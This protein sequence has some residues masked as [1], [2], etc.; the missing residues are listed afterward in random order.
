M[1]SPGHRSLGDRLAE[2]HALEAALAHISSSARFR[3]THEPHA[4]VDTA[5]AEPPLGNLEPAA[6][7]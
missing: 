4:M 2:G 5:G 7:I 6:P 1:R 3:L